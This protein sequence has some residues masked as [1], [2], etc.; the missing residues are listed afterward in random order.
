MKAIYSR[1]NIEL[2]YDHVWYHLRDNFEKTL[3]KSLQINTATDLY[4]KF[5]IYKRNKLW[6]MLL[7]YKHTGLYFSIKQTRPKIYCKKEFMFTY[8]KYIGN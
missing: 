6:N 8:F 7:K 2:I 4:S 1:E 3:D 5:I